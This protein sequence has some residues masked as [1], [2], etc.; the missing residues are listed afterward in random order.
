MNFEELLNVNEA[1]QM[2]RIRPSTLRLWRLQ[3]RLPVVKIGGSIR[4]RRKDLHDFIQSSVIPGDFKNIPND[5]VR[6]NLINER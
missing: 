2:L 6:P 5:E 3:G 4:F 1:A